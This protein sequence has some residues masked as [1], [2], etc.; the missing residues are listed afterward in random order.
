MDIQSLAIIAGALLLFS[1]ISGRLRDTIIT[2]PLE[3]LMLGS[4]PA[5]ASVRKTC[6]RWRYRCAKGTSIKLTK[7]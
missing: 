1:L 3:T 2:A 5:W 6:P 4:P 7:G